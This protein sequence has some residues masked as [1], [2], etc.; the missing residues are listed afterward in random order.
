MPG[1]LSSTTPE[2]RGRMTG[3]KAH[4][5]AAVFGSWLGAS[6]LPAQAEIFVRINDV[7]IHYSHDAW[8]QL[9]PKEAV[10]A[11]RDAGLKRAFVSSSGDEGTQMLYAQAPDLVVPVLRPYRRRGE[12][13]TWYR[14]EAVPKMLSDLMA[15][16]QYAGI[17]EF[18]IFGETADSPVMRA[19]VKLARKHGTFLHAHSDADAIDRIFAQDPSALVIWAHAGF[20]GPAEV[21]VMLE[22]YDNLWADLAFRSDHVFNGT[23]DPDWEA[24]FKAF[25][26][27]F[28]VG[29][30]TYTPER[31]YFVSEHASWCRQ[32]MS[33]L[34]DDLARAIAYGNA[35]MLLKRVA[36]RQKN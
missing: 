21:Q 7:H 15:R 5:I 31:W 23:V 12:T 33:E 24:L 35:E 10:K 28:M 25:P 2:P 6:A 1:A 34:S 8:D 32:W 16:N 9:P 20:D 26:G 22:K 4:W 29:T 11:L 19:V 30:D 36:E 13:A 14:D 27:R 18:H 17:G 3:S